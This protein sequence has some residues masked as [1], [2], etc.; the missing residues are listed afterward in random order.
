M[1]QQCINNKKDYFFEGTKLN[2][3]KQQ[4]QNNVKERGKEI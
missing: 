3:L 4:T 1:Y 2:F